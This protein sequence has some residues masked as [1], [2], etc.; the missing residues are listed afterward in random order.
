M[1]F[2]E[3][4]MNALKFLVWVAN[5]INKKIIYGWVSYLWLNVTCIHKP[6]FFLVIGQDEPKQT[7]RNNAAT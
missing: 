1:T 3:V 4:S 2:T 7:M 5:N 6:F